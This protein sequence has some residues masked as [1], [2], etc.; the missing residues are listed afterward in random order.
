MVRVAGLRRVARRRGPAVVSAAAVG[1]RRRLPLPLVASLADAR[2]RVRVV[3]G[4][5]SLVVPPAA[6]R[7]RVV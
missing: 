5:P 4:A 2:R 3:P 7:R 1:R 6:R